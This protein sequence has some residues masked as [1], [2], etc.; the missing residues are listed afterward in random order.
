[1]LHQNSTVAMPDYQP[2]ALADYRPVAVRG[3]GTRLPAPV[4]FA[5]IRS[6]Q[7]TYGDFANG[8]MIDVKATPEKTIAIT[9]NTKRG[10]GCGITFKPASGTLNTDGTA[11][12]LGAA[13]VLVRMKAPAGVTFSVSL[14]ESGHGETGSQAFDGFQFSDGE[15]YSHG[16]VTTKDG[17]QEYTFELKDF[18]R[19]P[20][21]G[22]QR[23]NGV[24]DMH[25]VSEIGVNFGGPMTAPANVEI[26]WIKV[27]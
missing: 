25:A 2:A 1:M 15:S 26:E 21:Y 9:L 23:G 12:L 8:S 5:D 14:N 24:I 3:A 18:E 16:Q 10:W 19:A 17:W 11:K 4:I 27:L 20:F 13:R 22:N 6:K 7:H